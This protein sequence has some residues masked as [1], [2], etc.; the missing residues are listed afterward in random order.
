MPK[1][2]FNEVWRAASEL[3]IILCQQI[4][5]ISFRTVPEISLTVE[6][7]FWQQLDFNLLLM[8]LSNPKIVLCN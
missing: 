3:C 5:M 4:K 1:C 8:F 2:D 6:T 7:I